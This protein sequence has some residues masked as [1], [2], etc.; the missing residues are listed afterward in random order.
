[1]AQSIDDFAK[2]GINCKTQIDGKWVI[3]RPLNWRKE[4]TTLVDRLWDALLILKGKAE[5][6][7]Y[8][9]Q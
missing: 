4:N 3:A 1:M 5:A 6:F 7:Y 2:S 9:K 8:Y